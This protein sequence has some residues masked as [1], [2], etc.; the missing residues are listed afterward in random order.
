MVQSSS[1]PV[2]QSSSLPW[3]YCSG[4]YKDPF[5]CRVQWSSQIPIRGWSN[6]PWFYQY[7][8]YTP[9]IKYH[10]HIYMTPTLFLSSIL[11]STYIIHHTITRAHNHPIITPITLVGAMTSIANHGTNIATFQTADRV[12]IS[13][14]AAIYL[15]YIRKNAPHWKHIEPIYWLSVALFVASKTI[16]PTTTIQNIFHA[17]THFNTTYLYLCILVYSP[18]VSPNSTGGYC[19]ISAHVNG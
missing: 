17:S 18:E 5:V 10:Q 15:Y 12:W 16:A 6:I 14:C 19:R 4:H 9:N 13:L 2:V 7:S 1:R 11:C 8:S 3:N